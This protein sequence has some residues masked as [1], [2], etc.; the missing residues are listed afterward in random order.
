MSEVVGLSFLVS[1]YATIIRF[2]TLA[3]YWRATDGLRFHVAF[4]LALH[5]LCCPGLFTSYERACSPCKCT[6]EWIRSVEDSFRGL[7]WNILWKS[8]ILHFAPLECFNTLQF[9]CLN[10]EPTK[11]RSFHF[12]NRC[13]LERMQ[14]KHIGDF[15]CAK[16]T[17]VKNAFDARFDLLKFRLL[18][19]CFHDNHHFRGVETKLTGFETKGFPLV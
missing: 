19:R 6:H 15:L 5:P 7:W 13:K 2:L 16:I 17:L 8:R 11:T 4:Q 9:E 10:P 12:P 18:A 14:S 1:F 3:L